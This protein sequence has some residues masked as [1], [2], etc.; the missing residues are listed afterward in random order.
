[1]QLDVQPVPSADEVLAIGRALER[2]GVPLGRRP[3]AYASA[4]RRAAAREAV[5]EWPVRPSYALSPRRTRGATR[6]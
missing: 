5:A 3:A 4:W 2:A 1:M 6:A